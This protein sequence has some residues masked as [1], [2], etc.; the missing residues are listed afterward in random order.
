M[1]KKR[2]KSF[3]SSCNQP[4][5]KNLPVYLP[6]KKWNSEKDNYQKYESGKETRNNL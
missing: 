5:K 6:E 2:W 4:Q 1:E 3:E